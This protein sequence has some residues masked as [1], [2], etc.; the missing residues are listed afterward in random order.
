MAAALVVPN[1]ELSSAWNSAPAAVVVA[2][3]VAAVR[4]DEVGVVARPDR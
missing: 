3:V 2:A 4:A 1:A